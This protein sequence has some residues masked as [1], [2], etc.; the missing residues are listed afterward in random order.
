[1]TIDETGMRSG[2]KDKGSR[3]LSGKMDEAAGIHP[4]LID[5]RGTA[6][7]VTAKK[8]T[9]RLIDGEKE[10]SFAVR[11][12]RAGDEADLATRMSPKG[13]TVSQTGQRTKKNPPTLRE[14]GGL[15]SQAGRDP[16][17]E[18]PCGA[19]CRQ[20]WRMDYFTSSKSTSSAVG[21]P[22]LVVSFEVV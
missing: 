7:Q 5:K 21:L 14:R 1:M 20:D 19:G 8:I 18:I 3:I 12:S 16:S 9:H 13:T 22:P 4:I 2:L 10:E 11:L 15:E 6:P 17:R